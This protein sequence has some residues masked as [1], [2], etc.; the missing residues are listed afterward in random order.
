[1][2][3]ICNSYRMNTYSHN[4]KPLYRR[5]I[6]IPVFHLDAA[7]NCSVSSNTELPVWT[8]VCKWFRKK[9]RRKSAAYRP[10]PI[11]VKNVNIGR[12]IGRSLPKMSLNWMTISLRSFCSV[13][14]IPVMFL[15]SFFQSL[16]DGSFDRCS[17]WIGTHLEACG[18]IVSHLGRA[19]WERLVDW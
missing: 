6:R 15:P 5:G 12:Y 1:M 9:Y 4:G 17:P 16:K 2:T 8:P 10:I 7:V 19:R 14:Q 3:S 13:P 11:H 18:L